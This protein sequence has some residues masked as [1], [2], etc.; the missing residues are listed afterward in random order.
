LSDFGSAAPIS[1]GDTSLKAKY[2]LEAIG[3]PDYIAPEI[4][5]CA[6]ISL[7]HEGATPQYYGCSVD[8]WS[9]GVTIFELAAGQPPFYS[10]SIRSTYEAILATTR[11]IPGRLSRDL[12]SF[13]DR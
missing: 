3:T 6:E 4:L 9:M 8:W 13:I 12:D 11:L 5:R 7:L 10:H 1:P 2:C